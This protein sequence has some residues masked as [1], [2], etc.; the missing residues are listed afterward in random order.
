MFGKGSFLDKAG[1]KLD[2]NVSKALGM[3]EGAKIS[4]VNSNDEEKRKES[5][6]QLKVIIGTKE[7]PLGN[8][9]VTTQEVLLETKQEETAI[10]PSN[11]VVVVTKPQEEIPVIETMPEVVTVE[12]VKPQE[13]AK[14]KDSEKNLITKCKEFIK[15][16]CQN[17]TAKSLTTLETYKTHEDLVKLVKVVAK[18]SDATFINLFDEYMQTD[19]FLSP[20]ETDVSGDSSGL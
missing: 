6:N 12:A 2:K 20:T 7:A 1:R 3:K 16:L 4:G 9:P 14:K 17:E 8:N 18:E 19:S 10:V 15:S 13:T 5:E 11:E